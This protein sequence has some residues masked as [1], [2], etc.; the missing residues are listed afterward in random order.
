LKIEKYTIGIGD[1]FACQGIAQLRALVQAHAAGIS[2]CPVWNKSNREHLMINSKPDDVRTEADHAVAKLGWNRPYYLDADH[3]NLKNVDAFVQASDYYTIDVADFIGRAAD[4]DAIKAFMDKVRRYTE[5]FFI[6]GIDRKLD[7][8]NTDL[9]VAARKFLMAMQE[10]ARIYRYIEAKKGRDNF[11]AE[12]SIDETDSAQSPVELFLILAMIG[13]EEI[14]VQMIAPKFTGRFNKG[15]D[16]AGDLTQFETEF[17][18]DLSVIAFAVSEFHL[19][20]TLK[21][22][23]HSG[24]DKFSIY[25]IINRLIKAR[26]AGL[27][28]KTAGTTWLEEV[29]G[30][31]ESGGEGLEIAKHIYIQAFERFDELAELYKTVIDI[32]K[33]KLP[34]PKTV[35]GWSSNDYVSA[36]RHVESCPEYNPH[37]RQLLHIGFKLAAEMGERFTDALRGNE[38]IIGRRV[39]ENLFQR[40]LLPVFG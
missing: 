5:Q 1:R 17:A 36:L 11:A 20:K 21:L 29:C 28:L 2:V 19:P 10:A 22:S 4:P 23:V 9:E 31:A 16:Y 7:L 32:D 26:G 18:E 40:H 12:I 8:G 15:I 35:V 24:S 37:L 39:T 27:H 14:P 33:N 3:I 30:L 34:D 13:L 38:E 25:P 6:P